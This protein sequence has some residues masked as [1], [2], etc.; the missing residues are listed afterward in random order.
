[1]MMTEHTEGTAQA[2]VK[3]IITFSRRF[4]QPFQLTETSSILY[5]HSDS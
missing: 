5:T 1:M 3:Y 2:K 4:K